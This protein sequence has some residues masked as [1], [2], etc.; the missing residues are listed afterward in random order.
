MLHAPH[1]APVLTA[2]HDDHRSARLSATTPWTKVVKEMLAN[3]RNAAAN[4]E[5][6]MVL[7]KDFHRI[8]DEEDDDNY[9]D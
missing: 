2:H 1:A 4:V 7:A 9:N 6:G 5:R 8:L 3:F